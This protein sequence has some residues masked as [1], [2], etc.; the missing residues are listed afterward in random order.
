[1]LFVTAIGKVA[2]RPRPLKAEFQALIDWQRPGEL[3]CLKARAQHSPKASRNQSAKASRTCPRRN[4]PLKAVSKAGI[5][6]AV[7]SEQGMCQQI[8]S[9]ILSQG[10]GISS[11]G[12]PAEIIAARLPACQGL[13][14]GCGCGCGLL[15]SSVVAPLS[16]WVGGR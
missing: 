3:Q 12:I 5:I 13:R 9:V 10:A 15:C 16:P 11:V 1:M 7:S 2:N 4:F 6:P 8:S 14:S